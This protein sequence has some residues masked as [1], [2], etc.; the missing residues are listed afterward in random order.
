MS[1]SEEY[2][3]QSEYSDFS[4]QSNENNED[5][6]TE[7]PDIALRQL[8]MSLCDAIGVQENNVE[9]YI[10]QI[11]QQAEEDN[12]DDIDINNIYNMLRN[13]LNID[14]NE[15]IEESEEDNDSEEDEDNNE[16]GGGF[17]SE[18]ED[19]NQ[20][21]IIDIDAI[22]LEIQVDD[23]IIYKCS[24]CDYQDNDM[25]STQDHILIVH[26]NLFSDIYTCLVCGLS[27][28]SVD[29]L[30]DHLDDTNHRINRFN[31]PQQQNQ[32]QVVKYA[33]QK[34]K[35][36]CPLCEYKFA[37]QEHLG[38]HF[39]EVH[40]SYEQQLTLDETIKV[41]AFPNYEILSNINMISK[42]SKKTTDMLL[43][44]Y[45][46]IC[47]NKYSELNNVITYSDFDELND[48]ESDSFNYPLL[49]MCCQSNVCHVC[50]RKVLTKN[51]ILKCPFCK[52]E[53]TQND[54]VRIYDETGK[55]NTKSWKKWHKKIN[56]KRYKNSKITKSTNM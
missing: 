53:H 42:P 20:D 9:N 34:G 1:D 51:A 23:N 2:S 15:E 49:M 48:E 6:E 50:I 12:D 24:K 45:C 5:N 36:K 26:N 17:G 19:I 40:A 35:F 27:Y 39:I 56:K 11:F 32:R 3:D 46:P 55:L 25:T 30:E 21:R 52:Y 10:N 4:D 43:K 29:D 16:N 37:T 31:V 13:D 22:I 14:I 44:N 33:T 47:D 8:C 28:E 7:H 41:N 38:E 54:Y 18:E